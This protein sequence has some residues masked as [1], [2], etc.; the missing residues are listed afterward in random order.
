MYEI[1]DF[2]YEYSSRGL[3]AKSDQA[4]KEDKEFDEDP[5]MDFNG[6]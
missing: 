6:L 1:D 4:T 5:P 3:I 2:C